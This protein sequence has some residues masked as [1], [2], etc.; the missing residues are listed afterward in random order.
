M[1]GKDTTYPRFGG[2]KIDGKKYTDEKQPGA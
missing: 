2:N 1:V